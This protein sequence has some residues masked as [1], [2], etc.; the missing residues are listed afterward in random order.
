MRRQQ[1]I[2]DCAQWMIGREGLLFVSIY[3]GAEQVSAFQGI[4]Q[5]FLVN[6]SATSHVDYNRLLWEPRDFALPDH[7]AGFV[8][9]WSVQRQDV[10]LLE[11][12]FQRFHLLN[13]QCLESGLR[14]IRI[15]GKA[16]HSE[17]PGTGP[18]PASDSPQ[19]DYPERSA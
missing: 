3:H 1:N 5:C 7:T 8:G 11:Q 13:P 10:G 12:V 19:P 18:D 16:A 15:V 6:D 9:Q 17:G 4:E 2:R 14:D